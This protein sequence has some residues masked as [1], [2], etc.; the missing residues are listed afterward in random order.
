MN[1]KEINRKKW[2]SPITGVNPGDTPEIIFKNCGA[3]NFSVERFIE[4]DIGDVQIDRFDNY[5]KYPDETAPEVIGYWREKGLI[6]EIHYTPDKNYIPQKYVDKLKAIGVCANEEEALKRY[7][8]W[9][10]Y[11]PVSSLED[12]ARK[13]PLLFLLHGGD[14]PIYMTETYGFLDLA[15]EKEIIVISPQDAGYENVGRLLDYAFDNYPV[16]PARV[17]CAGFSG[18]A[19]KTEDTVIA[20][21]EQFA[22]AIMVGQLLRKRFYGDP[23]NDRLHRISELKIPALN[24]EG[25]T[26]AGKT[27]PM[28]ISQEFNKCIPDIERTVKDNCEG[29]NHWLSFIRS[30]RRVTEAEMYACA[31]SA[32]DV[33][34]AIGTPFDA[35]RV[36]RHFDRNY[37]MGDYLDDCGVTL[38]RVIGVENVPHWPVPSFAEIGWDFVSAFTRDPDTHELRYNG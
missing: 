15:A 5:I 37:Y 27:L 23:S 34:R 11:I 4:G 9:A 29:L 38:L 17:Y 8:K 10:S 22:G 35:T 20:Y 16:D 13:Y 18:G 7:A 26:E 1:R 21:T 6:K 19:A 28:N 3:P 33:E 31:H 12:T 24:I 2:H 14:D 25:L 36:E 32:D 30:P